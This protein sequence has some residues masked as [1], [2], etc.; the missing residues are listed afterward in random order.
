M[1]DSVKRGC[2]AGVVEEREVR[3]GKVEGIGMGVSAVRVARALRLV[4]GGGGALS[5]I[6]FLEHE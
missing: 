5:P 2:C 4:S 3:A 1:L 6:L